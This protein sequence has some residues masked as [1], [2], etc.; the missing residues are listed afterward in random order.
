MYSI[1]SVL[2][3]LGSVRA[4][5]KSSSAS[6]LTS[7][8]SQSGRRI[9]IRLTTLDDGRRRDADLNGRYKGV[10]L[11]LI[12]Y[13]TKTFQQFQ[14]TIL[15]KPFEMAATKSIILI[16]GANAGIGFEL[17]S[18]LLADKAKHVIVG[19]RSVDKGEKA[20]QGLRSRNQPGT[21]EMVQL[22]VNERESIEAAAKKVEK[23]H[24][25]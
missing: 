3:C 23:D 8:D 10:V 9:L 1:G 6:L 19:S 4:S 17:A 15:R 18:Q 7:T 22:N 16:S 5:S 2:E 11:E 12:L 20:V 21:V 13:L 24:G 14:P 25:R